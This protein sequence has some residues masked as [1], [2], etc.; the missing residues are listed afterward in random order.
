MIK[1]PVDIEN[2]HSPEMPEARQSQDT[3]DQLFANAHQEYAHSKQNKVYGLRE[4]RKQEKKKQQI[5]KINYTSCNRNAYKGVR[6]TFNSRKNPS[7]NHK[8]PKSL[9]VLGTKANLVKQMNF[10]ALAKEQMYDFE[11]LQVKV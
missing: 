8:K 9:G 7:A 6:Q 3:L 10:V 4:M 11:E 2:E 5:E 1:N